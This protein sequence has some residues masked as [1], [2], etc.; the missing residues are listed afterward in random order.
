MYEGHSDTSQTLSPSYHFVHSSLANR[1]FPVQS[2]SIIWKGV[3]S[4]PLLPSFRKGIWEPSWDVFLFSDCDCSPGRWLGNHTSLQTGWFP[5][6]QEEG[7]QSYP[8]KPG[9]RHDSHTRC[10]YLDCCY[11]WED[12]TLENAHL[13]TLRT[14]GSFSCYFTSC[15]C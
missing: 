2:S 5:S 4:K 3:D 13:S 12:V 8:Q 7:M 1:F 6:K 15:P 14:P 10:L 11:A 9:S